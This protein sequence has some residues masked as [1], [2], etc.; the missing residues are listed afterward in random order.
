MTKTIVAVLVAAAGIANAQYT[1]QVGDAVAVTTAGIANAQFTYQLDDGSGENAIGLTT[2]GVISWGNMFDVVASS[3][4]VQSIEVGFGNDNTGGTL[5]GAAYAWV[6]AGDNDANP[7]TGLTFLA[8]GVGN[9]VNDDFGTNGV[10]DLINVGSVDVSGFANLF[11]AFAVAHTA[12]QFPA[13]IDT[14]ASAGRSWAAINPVNV[15]D[16]SGTANLIDNFGFAGNWIIRANAVPTPG[17]A[18]VLAL[19]GL[20]AIRRRR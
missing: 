4:I 16:W 11:V 9:I 5:V 12:G 7:T 19:A 2:G 18:G 13:A 3:A 15:G 6:I 14:T 20:G 1:Y 10:L 8:T 17:V